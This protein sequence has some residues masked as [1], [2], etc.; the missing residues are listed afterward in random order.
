M[1]GLK[2][3]WAELAVGAMSA[4]SIVVYLHIFKDSFSH[5]LPSGKAIAVNMMF[6]S[7]P[8]RSM[9]YLLLFNPLPTIYSATLGHLVKRID[10]ST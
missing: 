1:F 10:T 9:V 2:R 6:K 3:F 4:G 5:E 8:R 7:R